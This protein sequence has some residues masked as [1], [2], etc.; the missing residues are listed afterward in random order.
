MLL[1]TIHREE[2]NDNGRLKGGLISLQKF[3][4]E[5]INGPYP[6]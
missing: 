3:G 1:E 6:Y 4:L 5:P 2:H